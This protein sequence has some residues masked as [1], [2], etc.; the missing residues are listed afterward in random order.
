[1]N[2]L[3]VAFIGAIGTVLSATATAQVSFDRDIRPILS[4]H[5]LQC[6]GPDST[7]RK[8][9]LRLDLPAFAFADREHGAAIVPGD[10]EASVLLHRVTHSDVDERMPPAK[11]GKSLTDE[12]VALLRQWIAD[13]ADWP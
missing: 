11:I 8:A 5:C 3:L 13:G 12:Q 9:G 1:M 6:H 2:P 10:P 7:T 4:N